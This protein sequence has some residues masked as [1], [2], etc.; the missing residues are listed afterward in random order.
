MLIKF[1]SRKYNH[2][3]DVCAMGIELQILRCSGSVFYLSPS[4]L[5]GL[6]MIYGWLDSPGLGSDAKWQIWAG[7]SFCTSE[8][9]IGAMP[10]I[11]I[12]EKQQRKPLEMSRPISLAT[13][14]CG[15]RLTTTRVLTSLD[16][17][18]SPFWVPQLQSSYKYTEFVPYSCLAVSNFSPEWFNVRTWGQ[19]ILS[20]FIAVASVKRGGGT[21]MRNS[22]SVWVSNPTPDPSLL[23]KHP[24]LWIRVTGATKPRKRNCIFA[25]LRYVYGVE[26]LSVDSSSQYL[27]IVESF[28]VKYFPLLTPRG[29][30]NLSSQRRCTHDG[31]RRHIPMSDGLNLLPRMY[32]KESDSGNVGVLTHK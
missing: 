14:L 32:T 8:E 25:E 2:L 4:V 13:T 5:Q 22:V 17:S 11:L 6:I 7:Y 1:K 27:A 23:T 19:I 28:W 21:K 29:V 12:L 31:L 16:F 18:P 15:L 20:I 9:E 3:T 24:R 10:W 30:G 26:A